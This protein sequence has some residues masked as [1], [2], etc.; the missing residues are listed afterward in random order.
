MSKALGII[1]FSGNHI[2]VKGLQSYRPI[3]AMSFLGRYRVIDFP[4]S[5]MSNSGIDQ[6]QVYINQKRRS[7]TEHIGTGRHYNIN[8]KTWKSPNPLFMKTE[9]KTAFMTTKLQLT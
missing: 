8:S 1:N 9:L 6:I 4:L 7:L 2:W 5:N 3:G